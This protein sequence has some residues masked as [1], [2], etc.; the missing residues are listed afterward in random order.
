MRCSG[1]LTR[2]V[3]IRHRT[4]S[5]TKRR[6]YRVQGLFLSNLPSIAPLTSRV[7]FLRLANLPN[8]ALDRLS[9]YEATLW[10]QAGQILFALDALDRREPQERGRRFRIGSRPDLPADGRDD[11]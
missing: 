5:P 10:R 11:Y 8:F 9:R 4:P 3:S 1:G 2:S 6:P 7:A